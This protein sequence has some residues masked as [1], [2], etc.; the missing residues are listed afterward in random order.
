MEKMSSSPF[1]TVLILSYNGKQLLDDSISSYLANDYYNF[2]VVVIDNG[3]TD[4]TE[5]YVANKWPSV[6]LLRTEVNLKYSGGFNFGLKYAFTE[7]KS[8]YVLITNNDVKVDDKLI[9]STVATA[10]NNTKVGFVVGKVYYYEKPNTF[11]TCGRKFDERNL[12]G[13]DRGFQE[14][15]N[16]QFD[17]EV[18]IPWCDDVFWLVSHELYKTT[19]GYN[20]EFAF[21]GEDFEWQLRAK[22]AGFKIYFSPKAK[23]WH[24]ESMS[25]GKKSAFKSYYDFRNP[26]IVHMMHRNYNN[27]KYY[28]KMKRKNLLIQTIKNIMRFKFEYVIKSW[29]GFLSALKWGVKN[30]RI[31]ITQILK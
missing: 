23:L 21:Q 31:T 19:H 14:I 27:Y 29:S 12:R 2:E 8:D 5:E 15:D 28:F 1:V 25:I 20:T 18:E 24:K 6:K 10:L 26:L 22:K 9:S 3:S 30:K 13:L 4:G 11:Q 7:K 16:G 17:D